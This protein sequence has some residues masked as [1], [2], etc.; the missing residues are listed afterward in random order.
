MWFVPCWFH[1]LRFHVC[2]F[3]LLVSHDLPFVSPDLGLHRHQ[4]CHAACAA[5]QVIWSLEVFT[6]R[7]EKNSPRNGEELGLFTWRH[8]VEVLWCWESDWQEFRIGSKG[9]MLEPYS[10]RIWLGVSLWSNANPLDLLLKPVGKMRHGS[11]YHSCAT[12]FNPDCS[13]SKIKTSQDISKFAMMPLALRTSMFRTAQIL[14]HRF[15]TLPRAKTLGTQIFSS[16]PHTKA[17]GSRL[18]KVM[19]IKPTKFWWDSLRCFMIPNPT[20]L[21]RR[22]MQKQSICN[23]HAIFFTVPLLTMLHE[24][25]FLKT[26]TISETSQ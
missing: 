23:H 17:H 21:S 15:S 2:F 18:M 12:G 10:P 24:I 22:A 7:G 14:Q 25:C 1:V 26:I 5:V 16:C 3:L 20:N 6:H 19:K 8:R 4:T 11:C 9:G 13:G